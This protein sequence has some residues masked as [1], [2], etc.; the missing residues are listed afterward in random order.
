[1]NFV[2]NFL[3]PQTFFIIGNYIFPIIFQMVEPIFKTERFSFLYFIDI[4]HFIR[5]NE[6]HSVDIH[7]PV[8][9]VGKALCLL[10]M[11]L[12]FLESV[13]K[14]LTLC[15]ILCSTNHHIGLS[16]FIGKY[17]AGSIYNSYFT[18]LPY[19]SMCKFPGPVVF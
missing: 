6:I 12:A 8:A 4:I 3:L 17:F 19:N 14:L 2:I 7:G 5:P 11:I 10:K 9:D 1:M 18:V 15:N 16:L 13:N